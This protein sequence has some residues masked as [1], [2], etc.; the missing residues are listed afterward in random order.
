[1]SL[2]IEDPTA[3]GIGEGENCCAFLTMGKDGFE[4]ARPIP[5]VAATIRYR[6]ALGSMNSRYD[7]GEVA[8]PECQKQRPVA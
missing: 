4:C 7:P 2:L 5:D 3:C 8:F 6:L 1:M